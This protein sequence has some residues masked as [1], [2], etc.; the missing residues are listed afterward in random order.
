MDRELRARK[1]DS[2]QVR[3]NML[4]ARI[5]GTDAKAAEEREWDEVDALVQ[6]MLDDE[7]MDRQSKR[8]CCGSKCV[9]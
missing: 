5:V 6:E 4:Q 8:D 1:I 7:N 3:A 9:P 2:P